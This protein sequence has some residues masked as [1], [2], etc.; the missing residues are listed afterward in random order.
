M[1][2]QALHGHDT[3]HGSDDW[4]AVGDR[5]RQ[6]LDDEYLTPDG[7]YAHIRSN[8]IGALVGHRRGSRRALPRQ[9][10]PSLRRR[11]PRPCSARP[12]AR[13]AGCRAEDGDAVEHGGRRNAGP[14]DAARARASSHLVEFAAPVDQGDR[15]GAHGGRRAADR[16]RDRRVRS[17]VRDRPAVARATGGGR[18]VGLRLLHVAALVGAARSRPARHP[19]LGRAGRVHSSR[20]ART[21]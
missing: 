15:R 1:G 20:R 16:R 10:H 7:S 3:I 19:R 14:R 2:A 18:R 21:R 17:T 11:P 13:P 4:A 12:G 5:W 9:R 8:H 6:T